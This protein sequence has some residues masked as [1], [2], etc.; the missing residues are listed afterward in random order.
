MTLLGIT[1]LLCTYMQYILLLELRSSVLFGKL[2][3]YTQG[4]NII[5]WS[6]VDNPNQDDCR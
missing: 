2:N 4:K 5:F 3:L 1:L 6:W